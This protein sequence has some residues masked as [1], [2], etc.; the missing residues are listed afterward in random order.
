MRKK[1]VEFNG[2]IINRKKISLITY[3]IHRP[4]FEARDGKLVRDG[5]K[6]AFSYVCDGRFC[7]IEDRSEGDIIKARNELI[8]LI[9]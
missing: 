4:N 2:F 5:D 3:I 9:K 7:S 6:W 1:F 8:K